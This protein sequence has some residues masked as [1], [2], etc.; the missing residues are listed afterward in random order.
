MDMG[1]KENDGTIAHGII[2]LA[3]TMGL[4]VT[5]EGIETPAQLEMLKNFGCA[6]RGGKEHGGEPA[7]PERARGRHGLFLLLGELRA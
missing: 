3:K 2:A 7:D 5:A 1:H 4:A 6:D